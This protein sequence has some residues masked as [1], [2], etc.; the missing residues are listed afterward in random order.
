LRP[1]DRPAADPAW[2]VQGYD[3][4][5]VEPGAAGNADDLEHAGDD[6]FDEPDDAGRDTNDDGG[7]P[8]TPARRRRPSAMDG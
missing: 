2:S 7:P 8:T 1:V 4:V 6:D 3:N 5:D